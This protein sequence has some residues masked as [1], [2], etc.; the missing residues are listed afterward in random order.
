MNNIFNTDFQEFIISFNK[1]QVKYVLVGEYSVIIHGYRRTTGDMDILVER[2]SD[3]YRK[4]VLAFNEFGM[5]VFDMT[6]ETFLSNKFDV[7]TFGR[8]PVAIDLMTQIKGAEFDEIYNLSQIHLIDEIPVRVIHI[9]H[10][11]LTKKASGRHKD[12]D[13]IENLED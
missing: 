9:N 1:H 11:I 3:N 5:S 13:D 4:I 7:F 8:A 6:E 10:L 2:T 12:L